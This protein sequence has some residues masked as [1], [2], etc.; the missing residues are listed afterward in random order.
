[1]KKSKINR[2]SL[3]QCIY[4]GSIHLTG[5]EPM[6]RNTIIQACKDCGKL[7]IWEFFKLHEVIEEVETKR[8]WQFWKN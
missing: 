7:S 6:S 1:M 2:K 3:G 4:C 8:W 5:I